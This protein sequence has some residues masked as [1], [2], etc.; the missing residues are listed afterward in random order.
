MVSQKVSAMV[1]RKLK[2]YMQYAEHFAIP[3]QRGRSDF[4]RR[5]Q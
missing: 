1:S 5:H 4:L 3:P 2:A